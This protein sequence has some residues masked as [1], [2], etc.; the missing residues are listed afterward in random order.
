[1][2]NKKYIVGLFLAAACL[3]TLGANQAF[4][5]KS[6]D[7]KTTEQLR[8]FFGISNISSP[9]TLNQVIAALD[10]HKAAAE[11]ELAIPKLA[12]TL[13]PSTPSGETTVTLEGPN[14]DARNNVELL[15]FDV[16][17]SIASGTITS[18]LGS[19]SAEG[20][21]VSRIRIFDA[22]TNVEL[23]ATSSDPLRGIWFSSI[24]IP[25]Q[26]GQKRTLSLRLDFKAATTSPRLY[27][28]QVGIASI[29]AK[30]AN[31]LAV[32]PQN[33]SMYPLSFLGNVIQISG[34]N[35]LAASKSS[36]GSNSAAVSW[37]I[38]LFR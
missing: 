33:I 7:I 30:A 25:V 10:Y 11:K 15:R 35:R 8:L 29:Q 12:L 24:N 32:P 21:E 23:A 37:I 28:A 13:S 4:A 26:E 19:Y 16:S 20:L 22:L 9:A 2:N 6:F 18:L 17:A 14:R 34:G 31:G 5:A 27:R 36:A 1:M 38:N 3:L